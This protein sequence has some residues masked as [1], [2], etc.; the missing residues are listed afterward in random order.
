MAVK[1]Y[2]GDTAESPA[3]AV[4]SSRGLYMILVYD[5]DRDNSRSGPIQY[6]LST[7][8]IDTYLHLLPTKRDSYLFQ[9]K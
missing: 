2:D 9:V 4:E 3:V 5:W 7:F 6:M 1:W 8:Y